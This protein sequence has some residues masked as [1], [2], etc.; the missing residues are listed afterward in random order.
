MRYIS[1]DYLVGDQGAPQGEEDV[2]LQKQE[3]PGGGG[4]VVGRIEYASELRPRN[5]W[6]KTR[7][8]VRVTNMR[9]GRWPLTIQE[10]GLSED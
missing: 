8:A 6:F 7:V 1:Q 3:R 2:V 9:R 5:K 10:T 4:G